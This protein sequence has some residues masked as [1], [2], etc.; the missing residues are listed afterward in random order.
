[1]ITTNGSDCAAN[2][3]QWRT[4]LSTLWTNL[5]STDNHEQFTGFFSDLKIGYDNA[6]TCAHVCKIS[7][8][9]DNKK[10]CCKAKWE[11]I[12][13][14]SVLFKLP[15][16]SLVFGPIAPTLGHNVN[17]LWHAFIKHHAILFI[18][19]GIHWT[20]TLPQILGTSWCHKFIQMLF[21]KCLGVFNGIQIWRLCKPLKELKWLWC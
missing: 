6:Q 20:H 21:E 19:I 1:M 18:E 4:I 8:Y 7:H 5:S 9:I 17:C 16:K 3:I 10:V 15:T 14:Y 12:Y 2:K 11:I 13:I